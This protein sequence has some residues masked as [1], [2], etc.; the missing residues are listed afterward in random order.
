MSWE[1]WTKVIFVR[2]TVNKAENRIYKK[3]DNDYIISL[4]FFSFSSVFMIFLFLLFTLFAT[5]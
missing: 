4:L 5:I 3:N 2:L 1:L